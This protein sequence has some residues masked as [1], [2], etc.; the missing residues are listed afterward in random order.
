MSDPEAE[1]D[2]QAAITDIRTVDGPADLELPTAQFVHYPGSQ[3]LILW[4]PKPAYQGYGELSVTCNGVDIERSPVTSRVNGS[5]QILF[6]TLPWAPGEYLITITHAEGWRHIVE[7]SKYA[8]GEKP[9]LPPPP[10][11]ELYSGPPPSSA[12]IIYRDGFGKEL[13]N[14][15]LEM[16]AKA[17]R[18]T[19]G[20]F[21]RHVEYEG[22]FRGGT[23]T[24]IEGER[25]IRLW[26]E[27]C[28]GDMKFMI[29]IPPAE[30]WERVTGAPL[31]ERDDIVKFIAARVQQEKCA[32]WTYKITSS[33]IDFY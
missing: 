8:A 28:G 27:M 15:D 30:S 26:H 24:Y 17:Q 18:E 33:S 22:N 20:K 12:P 6:A 19:V 9:P 29:D 7:L 11:P 5:V 21:T 10:P 16:R 25:R 23:I 13:P 14:V 4:L 1:H 31:A 3:Q 2:G 32:T